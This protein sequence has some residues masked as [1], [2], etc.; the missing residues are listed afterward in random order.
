MLLEEITRRSTK[1]KASQVGTPPPDVEYENDMEDGSYIDI[2]TKNNQPK[3]K[4]VKYLRTSPQLNAMVND[5]W[6]KQ[7]ADAT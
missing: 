5:I 4:Q 6:F 2:P 3:N 7:N 1:T